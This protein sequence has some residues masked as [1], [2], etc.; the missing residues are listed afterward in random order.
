MRYAIT[1]FTYVVISMGPEYQKYIWWKKYLTT[2]QLVQFVI[3][4]VHSAQLHYVDCGYPT[5]MGY[6]LLLHSSIFLVL[7]GHFYYETYTPSKK[8]IKQE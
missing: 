6:L 2:L 3:V 8:Q 4:F 5:F 7:F 1:S